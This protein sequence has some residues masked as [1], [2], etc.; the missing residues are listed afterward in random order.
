MYDPILTAEATS[1]VW[2][3]VGLSLISIGG[4][5]ALVCVGGL[6]AGL[7]KGQVE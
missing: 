1:A 2:S 7:M 4:L 3:V 6:I 5:G